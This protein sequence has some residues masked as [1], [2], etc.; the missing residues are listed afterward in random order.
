MNIF[1]QLA[2]AAKRKYVFECN[3]KKYL[4][5]RKISQKILFFIKNVQMVHR[6]TS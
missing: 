3:N 2:T 4:K 1:L 5:E 6:S